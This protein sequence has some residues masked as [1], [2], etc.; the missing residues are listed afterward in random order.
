MA[1]TDL[2]SHGAPDVTYQPDYEK[3][4][5]RTARRLKED[6]N[7]P[8]MPLPEGFPTQLESPLVWDATDYTDESQWVYQLSDV[9]LREIDDAVKY[10]NS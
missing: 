7:L 2:K 9:H 1:N 5:A 3:W 6:P 8:N 10:F 4:R